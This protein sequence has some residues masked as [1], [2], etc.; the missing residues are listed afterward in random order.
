MNRFSIR[1]LAGCLA[2]A[3][4]QLAVAAAA[5]PLAP[6]TSSDEL[7]RAAFEILHKADTDRL[8]ELW[9]S[10]SDVLKSSMS[11]TTFIQ[12]TRKARLTMGPVAF[13]EWSSVTRLKYQAGNDSGVP[14]GLYANVE[15]LT[16]L[17]SGKNASERISFALEKNVWHFTGYA[18][19]RA[20]SS[21]SSQSPSTAP[22]ATAAPAV[23]VTPATPAI[24]AT[25]AAQPSPP[26]IQRTPPVAQPSSPPASNAETAEVE[27]AVRAWG[28][29]WSARD[30][31]R[32]LSAYASDFAPASG[33][34]RKNWEEE[35]RARIGGKSSISVTLEKL[36]VNI[37][38][39]SASASFR[40][41]YRADKLNQTD[42]KTLELRRVGG[43]WLIRKETVGA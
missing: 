32:Y 26:A 28:A 36:V 6:N 5:A 27:A 21:Q 7:L 30:V 25:P 39:Q 15:L 43:Q 35:R 38:G 8:G 29:A 41:T 42:R 14:A 17:D 2:A 22:D 18:I 11:K 1:L 34:S 12:A 3:S 31:D 40:Q 13:R 33:L 24:S 23:P 20:P 16:R 9:E 10:G 19:A 37:D 4:L